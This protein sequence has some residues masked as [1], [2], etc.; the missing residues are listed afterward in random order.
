[1]LLKLIDILGI[2]R[3]ACPSNIQRTSISLAGSNSALP[4]GQSLWNYLPEHTHIQIEK[5]SATEKYFATMSSS[6]C[7][8][9]SFQNSYAALL[10]NSP[11]R[12]E[13]IIFPFCSF[14]GRLVHGFRARRQHPFRVGRFSIT[15]VLSCSVLIN[16]VGKT[17]LTLMKNRPAKSCLFDADRSLWWKSIDSLQSGMAPLN[18]VKKFPGGDESDGNHDN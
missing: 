5:K 6:P 8:V 9:M 2:L 17:R 3:H 10:I 1:M 14:V 13:S 15:P 12:P 4:Y 7:M 11:S 16:F 18:G